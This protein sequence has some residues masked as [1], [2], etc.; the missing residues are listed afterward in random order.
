MKAPAQHVA[1]LAANVHSAAA[2]DIELSQREGPVS[3]TP[4]LDVDFNRSDVS[5]SEDGWQGDDTFE[6]WTEYLDINSSEDMMQASSELDAGDDRMCTCRMCVPED[7]TA[8]DSPVI[9]RHPQP[10]AQLVSHHAGTDTAMRTPR[11]DC[12]DG[13]AAAAGAPAAAPAPAEPST[14]PRPP[15]P[16]AAASLWSA[17]SA[18][19]DPQGQAPVRAIGVTFSWHTARF[20]LHKRSSKAKS[21]VNI[22]RGA[23]SWLH[24][25]LIMSTELRSCAVLAAIVHG[26]ALHAATMTPI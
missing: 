8:A 9:R 18:A 7:G 14:T 25:C 22:L 2:D 26:V 3:L 1:M 6:N 19:D 16:H 17:S 23:S 24:E 11:G 20:Q 10:L 13:G 15:N 4:G 12:G 5:M 21:I